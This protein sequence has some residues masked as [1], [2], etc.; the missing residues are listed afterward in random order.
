[1][2]LESQHL[3][4]DALPW[5]LEPDADNPGVRYFALRD[6]LGRPEDDPEVDKAR[7]EVMRTGPVPAILEAQHREGYWARPGGGYAPSYKATVWQIIF[8][9]ELG[10]DPN[11][12]RVR[13]GC[14]YFL[15]HS[16]AAN[17]GFAMNPRPTP[18]SVV[19]CLNG[20]PI[21]ALVR[22]GYAQEPRL[23]AALD[24]L[25][26]ATTG[27]GDV[28]FFKSGTSG[29]G[30]ACAYN[31][32]QPCAWGATKAMK[33]LSVLPTDLR[34]AAVDRAIK[35]GIDFL[36]GKDLAKAD[37]PYTER[38]N[39]TWFSF[40]FPLSYRSDVLE[41][42]MVLADL[43]YGQDPRLHNAQQFIMSKQDSQGRWIMEKTLNGKMW[44]D[45]EEKGRPSKWITLRAL[46]ALRPGELH[47]VSEERR[48]G[49]AA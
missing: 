19:H 5:L 13:R 48:H 42:A 10:A 46:R 27:V 40:G 8:L 34:T 3:N 1:M 47:E 37:Y 16:V 9:A 31:Q 28:R 14:E 17:G 39:S 23:H 25:V 33:T 6:L 32:K 18:S 38:I 41:T 43:G 29:I 12:E 30:F 26:Q 4:D 15:N 21:Y 20:D 36:L 11:D 24:W 45:V 49:E 22:L 44:A 7:Q 2:Q 35:V